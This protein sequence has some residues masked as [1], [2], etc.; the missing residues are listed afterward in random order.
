[1]FDE[2]KSNIDEGGNL[3]KAVVSVVIPTRNEED[4]I[5][6]CLSSVL[7]QSLKPLEII[8]VD[9]NSTDNTLK[10]ARQFPVKVITE[11]ESPSLPNARNLGVEAAVGEIIF[12]IDSDVILEKD[13]IRNAIK[14]FEDPNTIAVIPSEE[15]IAHT[16]LEKIL[17]NWG[18]GTANSLRGIGISVFSEFFRK[19]VFK[20][21]TFDR[22]LGFGEDVDFQKRLKAIYK[23]PSNL[24]QASD[25]KISF[26]HPH[27]LKELWSQYT[28]YGRTFRR[29]LSKDFSI[30]PL[31]GFG[32]CIAATICVVL[33]VATIFFFP[34]FT[35]LNFGFWAFGCKKF[36]CVLSI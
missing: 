22:N 30:Q 17:M 21:V 4:V 18:R 12:I 5:H 35:F 33:G 2:L 15:S 1:M 6:E 8:I 29:Y 10:V 13:C 19:I 28:W 14:Y 9:G 23:S 20:Q 11:G 32:S 3:T 24:I 16:R 7:N 27:S 26:H 36:D 31:L 25:S 34:S